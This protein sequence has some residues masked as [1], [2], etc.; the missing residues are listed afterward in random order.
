MED[1]VITFT[2][3]TSP[4]VCHGVAKL[5]SIFQIANQNL[6]VHSSSQGPGAK[7]VNTVQ[8]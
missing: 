7:E 8:V 4:D 6:M 5:L 3:R 2:W 1:V